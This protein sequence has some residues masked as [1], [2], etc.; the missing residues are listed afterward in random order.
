MMIDGNAECEDGE[1]EEVGDFC[2]YED[3]DEIIEGVIDCVGICHPRV[4][5]GDGLCDDP[6]HPDYLDA[7]FQTCDAFPASPCVKTAGCWH[8][9]KASWVSLL[10]SCVKRRMA[11]KASA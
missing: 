8:S 2:Y 6:S 5:L 9:H 7:D 3:S 10:R 11:S 4:W 1:S